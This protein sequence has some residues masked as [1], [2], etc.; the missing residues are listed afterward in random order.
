MKKLFLV[1]AFAAGC[2]GESEFVKVEKE[3]CACTTRDC[4]RAAEKKLDKL[5]LK[6]LSDDD[7]KSAGEANMRAFKCIQAL[8]KRADG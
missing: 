8:E 7:P 1:L 4:A 5:L 3:A 2:K 6:A